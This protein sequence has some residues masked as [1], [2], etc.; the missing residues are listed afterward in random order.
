[1]SAVIA[2]VI[3]AADGSPTPHDNRWV[4]AWNPHTEAGTLELTSTADIAEAL[5]F[6]NALDVLREWQTVSLVEPR[7][8]WDGRPNRPLTGV[9]IEFVIAS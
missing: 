7:R 4:K 1:M 9:T 6:E 5:R 3:R 2:R 8:P